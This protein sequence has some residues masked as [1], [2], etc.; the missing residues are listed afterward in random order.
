MKQSLALLLAACLGAVLSACGVDK[1]WE[2]DGQA[3]LVIMVADSAGIVPG[4]VKDVPFF[5]DST[6]VR[7]QAR[8]QQFTA[9]AMTSADGIASFEQLDS[10]TYNVFARREMTIDNNKKLF[11]GSFEITVTGARTMADTI[12]VKL[13][14]ASQLMI[15]EINYCGSCA[16]TFYFY[17]E[18]VELYNASNVDMYLDGKVITRGV[19]TL[20]PLMESVDYTRA[21]YAYQFP[22]TP[23]TGTEYPIHPGEFVVV[24]TDAVD[25]RLYCPSAQDLSHADWEMFNPLGNDY[26][27]VAVPNLV[28]IMPN[29]TTDFL[30]NLVHDYILLADGS[31]YNMDSDGYLRIPVNTVVDGVEYSSNPASQK[32]V[33]KRIDAGF[34]GVGITRYSGYSIERRELGLDTNDSTFDFTNLMHPTPGRFH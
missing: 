1:P 28:N 7:I 33:T 20:D 30:I 23:V 4:S 8:N 3:G 18:F 9:A 32:E 26:D 6:E 2:P 24:A 12:F 31:E 22:G 34:A 21:I 25:H 29:R 15:N 10:G 19:S 13:I 14:A 16:S 11:T 27:N 17:D 5:L